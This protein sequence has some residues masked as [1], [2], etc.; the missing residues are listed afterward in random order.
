[1]FHI[2]TPKDWQL[3]L[4]QYTVFNKNVN[5]PCVLCIRRSCDGK[6][7]PIQF[8]ATMR[9][10]VMIVIFPLVSVGLDQAS[11][12]YYSCN[13]IASVYPEHLA[14]ICEDRR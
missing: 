13:P 7:L 5:N 10:Y 1:M 8:A 6:S 2:S 12:L 3:L 14:S 9:R 11:N 4:I